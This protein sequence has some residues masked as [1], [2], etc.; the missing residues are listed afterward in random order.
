MFFFFSCPAS[1]LIINFNFETIYW[2]LVFGDNYFT[3]MCQFVIDW[4][5]FFFSLP[6]FWIIYFPSPI[7]TCL[8][9]ELILWKLSSTNCFRF[10]FYIRCFFFHHVLIFFSLTFDIKKRLELIFFFK[11][12]NKKK[13]VF[14]L[15][16]ENLRGKKKKSVVSDPTY[17]CSG[18]QSS[19]QTHT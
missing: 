16:S 2:I 19:S 18:A 14:P 9:L 10:S 7:L 6:R 13:I 4:Y 3:G 8:I 12:T 1:S 11:V 17:R 15:M 5:F